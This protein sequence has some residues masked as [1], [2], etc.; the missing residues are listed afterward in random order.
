MCDWQETR[1]KSEWRILQGL[2]LHFCASDYDAQSGQDSLV[3][4]LLHNVVG[5]SFDFHQGRMRDPVILN[6][7]V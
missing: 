1:E 6:I 7:F 4:A 3:K 5:D 2:L